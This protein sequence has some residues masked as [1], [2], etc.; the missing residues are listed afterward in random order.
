M[1]L[2]RYAL[3]H[4]YTV[5][6]LAILLLLFGTLALQR[7]STDILPAVEI[8]SVNVVWIYNGL[9]AREMAS[10][11]TSFSEIAILNNVD[12]LREVRSDTL[13][14][15]AVIRVEFQ[16]Y[17][18]VDLAISQITSVSQTILRRMPPGTQPPVIVRYSQSSVPILQLVLASDAMSGSALFDY[19][20]LQLR[21]QIQTIPGIRMTLPYGGASRQIMVDLDPRALEAYGLSPADVARA[22]SAQN[23]TLPSGVV[24]E[25]QRELQVAVNASPVEVAAFDQ[26]PVR[27]V[28]G[29]VIH[30]RDVASVRDGTS[31]QTNIAR[32]NG[33]SSVTVS[34]IKL[35]GASTVAIVSQV[36][37]RLSEI[38]A[39]APPGMRIEPIF[40][41][42]VFVRAAI[43]SV[44]TEAVIV[45]LLV[46]TVVL[47]FLAS[48]RSTLIVLTSI[49]LALL[50]SI[51]GLHVSGH[52]FN[53]MTL[54]GLALAIG[55]L[56]DN[57]L[58]EIE[59]IN[60]NLDAGL[61]LRE[62]ILAGARQVFFP[63]L[64]STLAI[65]I[66]FTPIFLLTGVAAYVFRPLALAVVFAMAAS[67]LLSRTLVP[68]LASMLLTGEALARGRGAR[69]D[70]DAGAFQRLRRAY[71]ALLNGLVAR[72]AAVAAIA[73]TLVGVGAYIAAH[74]GQDFFPVTDAGLMKLY[75]RAPSGT[76]LEETARLFADIQRE[77]RALVPPEE[78]LFIAENIG[79]PEPV[80]LAWVSSAA[81]GSF[82]GEVQIQLTPE[83]AP[84]A[85]YMR[86][87]REM[88]RE[89]FPA[90]RAYFRPADA[91]GQTLAGSAPAA[92]DVRIVGRDLPGNL[93]IARTL[94]R[95][96]GEVPGLAD[97]TLRQVLDLPEYFIE[98]DRVRALQ[99]GI[100]Q[101]EASNAVLGALGS[102]ATV[103]PSFWAD[104]RTGTSYA[105]QVH[106]PPAH[107]DSVED[108]LN[109]PVRASASGTPILL[110]AVATVSKRQAPASVS[111]VTLAPSLNV[112][113][114]VQDRDLGGAYHAVAAILGELRPQLKPGNRIEVTGQ[115]EAMHAAYD[116]LAGGL[117]LAAVLVFLVMVVK[118]Q[119]W[120]LPLVA[121]SGLPLALSGAATGLWLTGTNLSVPALMGMIM[122]VGVSTAN[123]V[124]VTS[125]ARDRLAAGDE[126]AVAAVTAAAT[127]LRPV[128][129]TAL[130]MVVGILP[131]ALG[132]GEG[133]EQNAPLGRAVVGGLVTGTA[134]TLLL[135]PL[136]FAAAAR[137]H[138]APARADAGAGET[139]G[140]L[141]P[142]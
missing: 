96:L 60:R 24:R 45:A 88:L 119:S 128:L 47:T 20:R 140:A 2:V 64:V 117:A 27:E 35:G 52:T 120:A 57:A 23:L 73:G 8:P 135:V 1:W 63:E 50:A 65:C 53:L 127:R 58:V 142:R 38:R 136:A 95:R 31:V 125:F 78:L 21:S 43:G 80:N 77:V 3:D 139:T 62:A 37:E 28:D 72:K 122:V 76:R 101:Q 59:N 44:L 94:E 138:P 71:A 55:I 12:D 103:S 67:F 25:G 99:L 39:S 111:R 9:N 106:T 18:D 104:V 74:L 61:P 108:L 7:A 115:A 49:P 32:L 13:N 113:A 33:E 42:S 116:D 82:D 90:V 68:T 110:R 30:L 51:I 132:F 92:L 105:V 109:L 141:V 123:S 40:D 56:V 130:A 89:R 66:V 54:G 84:S 112:L 129:M 85:V 97:V 11:I 102:T 41:Q 124:L 34:I 91:T 93:A 134:A 15:N 114:N 22:V 6:V 131:M 70:R 16:P 79:Q 107:L 98:V 121:M 17:V 4:R 118:F 81:S 48:W 19:A 69:A 14:G 86:A 75:L 83:H 46:A 126:P 10:K 26:L 36:M 29:R 87:I 5:A 100:T 137:A 133:G